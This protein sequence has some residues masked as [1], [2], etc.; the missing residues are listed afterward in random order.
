MTGADTMPA[1]LPP[2]FNTPVAAPVSDRATRIVAAQNGPSFSSIMKNVAIRASTAAYGAE[3]LT[4]R[5]NSRPANGSEM[6]G[7][8]R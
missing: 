3:T 4:V 6:I 8:R 7:T 1:K 5:S 2:V